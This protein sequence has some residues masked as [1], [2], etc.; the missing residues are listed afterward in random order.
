M[1]SFHV[2]WRLH[3]D[4]VWVGVRPVM[5]LKN[6]SPIHSPMRIFLLGLS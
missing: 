5:D 4:H 1:K 2:I 6:G 3:D